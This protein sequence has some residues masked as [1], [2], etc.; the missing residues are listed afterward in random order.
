MLNSPVGS[1]HQ[2]RNID[3]QSVDILI[4]IVGIDPC[5]SGVFGPGP[6]PMALCSK[7]DA[8]VLGGS[9][10]IHKGIGVDHTDIFLRVTGYVLRRPHPGVRP[11]K[12]LL[13]A[14]YARSPTR[15]VTLHTARSS[16]S[17]ITDTLAL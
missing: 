12:I 11:G 1:R 16:F 8:L 6:S 3:I 2:S 4:C 14:E 15:I 17:I 10:E 5:Q 13:L 9:D 7:F